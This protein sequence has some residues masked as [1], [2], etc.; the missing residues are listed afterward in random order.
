MGLGK[1]LVEAVA[2]AELPEEDC[3]QQ[4]EQVAVSNHL[5]ILL[6]PDTQACVADGREER[7]PVV[8]DGAVFPI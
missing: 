2:L 3:G 8:A 1:V 6:T 5:A 4:P 7:P